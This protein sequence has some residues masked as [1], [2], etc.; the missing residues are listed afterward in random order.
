MRRARRWKRRAGEKLSSPRARQAPGSRRQQQRKPPAV[1]IR[2][3]EAPL[4]QQPLG[5]PTSPMSPTTRAAV[6]QV[7]A[8][9]QSLGCGLK[10]SP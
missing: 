5:S 2:P 6:K 1:Q 10:L 9:Y 7:T 4:D 8:Q 3:S